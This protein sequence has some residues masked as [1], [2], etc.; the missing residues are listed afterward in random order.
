MASRKL[1]FDGLSESDDDSQQ[2]N[3]CERGADPNVK[4]AA[5]S[6]RGNEATEPL[7]LDDEPVGA[8]VGL[9]EASCPS[10]IFLKVNLSSC[11]KEFNM[12]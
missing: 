5:I 6:G 10:G 7:V 12:L 8:T 1:F 9:V 11:F 4:M 2:G 3:S